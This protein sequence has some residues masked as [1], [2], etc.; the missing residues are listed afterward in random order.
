MS[1]PN[2]IAVEAWN[3]LD[4][5][6]LTHHNLDGGKNEQGI[7]IIQ[8][9]IEEAAGG[10][11]GRGVTAGK[12]EALKYTTDERERYGKWVAES[13]VATAG[14]PYSILGQMAED[15]IFL[16]DAAAT[17]PH[18][19]HV[20]SDVTGTPRGG[21]HYPNIVDGACTYCGQVDHVAAGGEPR[22]ASPQGA[23]QAEFQDAENLL[24]DIGIPSKSE[25]G[26]LFNLSHRIRLLSESVL[27]HGEAPLC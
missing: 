12:L 22:K 7:A 27:R 24:N 15:Y 21:P 18:K 6:L 14:E 25:G 19:A 3:K 16:D 11:Y 23:D 8:S 10:E 9:A 20:N 26:E 1:T 5:S 4:A 13:R 2:Q 17:E